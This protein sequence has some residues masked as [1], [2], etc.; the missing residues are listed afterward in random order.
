MCDNN[1][2]DTREPPDDANLLS[3]KWVR[4]VKS[5]GIHK[6]RVCGRLFNMIKGVDYRE[7]FSPV[8]KLLVEVF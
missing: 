5:N 6:S 7:T 4:A 2:W 8:S 3:S 1:V